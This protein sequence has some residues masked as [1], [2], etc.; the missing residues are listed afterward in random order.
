MLLY[1]HF[2]GCLWYF[3]CYQSKIW[4]APCLYPAVSGEIGFDAI[5]EFYHGE[6]T[7]YKYAM[8]FYNSV[9]MIKGNEVAPR[10]NTEILASTIILVLDLFISANV[11]GNVAVLVKQAM[12]KKDA[13]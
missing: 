1:F 7:A 9:I 10:T 6:D 4:I 5:A 8:F 3:L 11:F 13:F 12:R 2:K